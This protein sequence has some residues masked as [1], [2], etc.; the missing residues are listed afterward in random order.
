MCHF[1]VNIWCVAALY[2]RLFLFY[3][4]QTHSK[5]ASDKLNSLEL[6]LHNW[7][8]VKCLKGEFLVNLL[9]F[10]STTRMIKTSS[11]TCA[12]GTLPG[13]MHEWTTT[14]AMTTTMTTT[15]APK[16]SPYIFRMTFFLTF[17]QHWSKD[18]QIVI[19]GGAVPASASELVLALLNADLHPLSNTGHDFHVVPT[20]TELFGHQT[21]DAATE[22]GLSAQWWVLVAHCQRPRRDVQRSQYQCRLYPILLSC[23][24]INLL[25]TSQVAN[26][27]T[28]G[29]VPNYITRLFD[30]L[31]V[32]CVRCYH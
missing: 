5:L 13:S 21:W 28:G 16:S 23:L 32:C 20:E 1:K 15:T 24:L 18:G 2:G 19:D 30:C 12:C 11:L 29:V 8:P 31:F 6:L 26:C 3:F 10:A 27:S 22:D 7:L 4:F 17:I 14:T 25:H 9:S